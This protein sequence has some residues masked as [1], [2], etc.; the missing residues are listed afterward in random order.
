MKWPSLF[1]RG[2]AS[3]ILGALAIIG[4]SGR[5]SDGAGPS[6]GHRDVPE[7]RP[8]L[9]RSGNLRILFATPTRLR[10]DSFLRAVTT[11][12]SLGPGIYRLK[13]LAADGDS[14]TLAT[15]LPFAE[16]NGPRLGGYRLGSWPGERTG[17]PV[18]TGFIQVTAEDQDVRVSKHFR[19]RDFLTHDQQSVWPKY[20][21]L[22]PRLI[23]KLE[24]ISAALVRLGKSPRI[25]VMSG[26]RTPQYN[27][28][29]VGPLGGRAR[30]SRHTYGDAA[31]IFVDGDGNGVM[32]DLDGD[33]RVTVADSRFLLALA[34]QVERR[35]PDLV[36]GLSAYPANGV[37]GPFLHVDTRG[38][39]ARW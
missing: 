13:A 37:H 2:G 18:P 33:G 12:L 3:A 24:L 22:Q 20:L 15:L 29:G 25:H 31:D 38:H 1:G 21:V 6:H 8:E 11:P 17:K 10:T 7:T 19:L 4:V 27:A 35:F 14:L 30:D 28:L 5:R 26:F 9:G 34:E 39:R 23:D 16:K 32:D 36:G